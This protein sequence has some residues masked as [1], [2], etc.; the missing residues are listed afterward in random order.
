M[1]QEI[2]HK[3]LP[4]IFQDVIIITRSLGLQYIWIDALCIIQDD[5]LDW[6]HQSAEMCVIYN[7]ACIVLAATK[8]KD[9]DGDM[10]DLPND[11]AKSAIK[12]AT[13]TERPV[14]ALVRGLTTVAGKPHV[15]PLH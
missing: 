3:S 5:S 14:W 9:N 13:V 2:P 1:Q 12:I 4:Q 15:L 7:N 6:G 10:L 8:A 11:E